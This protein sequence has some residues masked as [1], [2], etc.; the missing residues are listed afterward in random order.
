MKQIFIF[1]L[2]FITLAACSSSSPT[3]TPEPL[4]P[5]PTAAPAVT[6]ITP[7]EAPADAEA[8]GEFAVVP[9]LIDKEWA[10]ENR[11]PNGSDVPALDVPNPEQYTLIFAADG[12]FSAKVDCNNVAGGYVTSPPDSLTFAPGPSTLVACPPGTLDQEML[13]L[14]AAVDSFRFIENGNVLILAWANGGPLDFFRLHDPADVDLP[15]PAEDPQTATAKV[16]AP[17]GIFLRTGPGTNYPYVGAAPFDETGEIIGVSE[18][19]NWWL[20]AAPQQHGGQVWVSGAFVEVQNAGNVPVVAAHSVQ[21]DLV[22][23]PW[24]WVSTTDPVQGTVYVNDPSRYLV[25]FE[26]DNTATIQ[27]DCNHVQATYTLSGSSLTITPQTSTRVACPP[28]S[29]ADPFLQQLQNVTI[30]HIQGGNLYLDQ[31]ADGGTMRFVAQGAPVPVPDAPAAQADALTFNLVSF[32]P[33]DAPQPV[34]AGTTITG[35]LADDLASGFA[36]CNN[37]SGTV[38]QQSGYF[39]ISNIVTTLKTCAEPA[40]VMEQEQA[41]LSALQAIT[42]NQWIS[43]T[44]NGIEV[45]TEGKLFY[46]LPNGGEGVMN[47]V[48]VR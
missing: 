43:E 33:K 32:G 34:I 39:T 10:W 17:D 15:Q 45:I 35:H 29:Q 30:Y 22:G 27:A 42:G 9:D 38:V 13:K 6:D 25:H 14:F 1:L 23:I 47:F 41:F 20:I 11:D 19:G 24:E 21:A 48:A 31:F 26:N 8:A 12:S 16:T 5:A 44:I 3:P 46:R 37:Y 7:T 2:L 36:G 40:G 4:T 28:D 18:D